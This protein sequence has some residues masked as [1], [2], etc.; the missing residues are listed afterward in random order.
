MSEIVKQI[1]QYQSESD[2]IDFKREQYPIKSHTKK[3]EILKDI[4]AMANH[5][6]NDDK[7]IIIGVIEKN[8]V[9]SDFLDI[10]AL[11]DEAKY[12]QFVNNNIEPGIKFEYKMIKFENH[13]LA[14]FRIFKNNDRPYL[15]KKDVVNATS[16]K[17]EFKAGDGFIRIG[18]STKKMTRTDYDQVYISKL[19][20]SDRKSDISITPSIGHPD[21][22]SLEKVE[23]KYLDVTIE[24]ISNQSIDLDIEMK[25]FKGTSYNLISKHDLVNSLNKHDANNSFPY[26]PQI[27]AANIPSF[28]VSFKDFDQYILIS[29]ITTRFNKVAVSIPQRGIEKNIFCQEMLAICHNP[30]LI[31]GEITIRSDDFVDGVL[32][33]KI[34]FNVIEL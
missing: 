30:V 19:K 34:E 29:R 7:Y 5:P 32:N 16:D 10:E 6:L 17:I 15:F 22:D 4:S 26:S 12:Q 23:V 13:R 11:I 8:G 1:L 31:K 33:Q 14:Y 3:H 24:N 18:T 9:A 27:I 25:I 21:D 28:D 20:K 2:I